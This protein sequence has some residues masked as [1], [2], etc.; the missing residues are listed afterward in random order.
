[1]R[2]D[3]LAASLAL[4]LTAAPLAA[5]AQDP[6]SGAAKGGAVGAE[7]GS[8]AGGPVGGVV[9]G[10]VGAAAGAV[11]GAAD[12]VGDVLG[13]DERPRFREE[14]VREHR[15]SYRYAEPLRAGVVLPERGVTY[16]DVPP[17]YHVKPGYRYTIVNERPVIV[18]PRTRKVIEVIE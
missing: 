6:V 15:P 9:G 2:I 13:A 11:G 14:V 5:H 4:A 10:A 17:R 16:Y 8:E 1:M 7:E 3:V 18:E 12:V